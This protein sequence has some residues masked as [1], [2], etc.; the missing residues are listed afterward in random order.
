MPDNLIGADVGIETKPYK[1]IDML[2]QSIVKQ[3]LPSVLRQKTST[4][5]ASSAIRGTGG[6]AII[7]GTYA[8][9]R[10]PWS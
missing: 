10:D 6:G 8:V 3:H 9:Y 4:F 7:E 1:E 5:T 2:K